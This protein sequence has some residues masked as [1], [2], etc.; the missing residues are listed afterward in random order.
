[1]DIL[2]QKKSMEQI[3]D[4]ARVFLSVTIAA[5]IQVLVPVQTFIITT[6]VCVVAD[7]ITGVAAASK[8]GERITSYGFRR[9]ILKFLMYSVAIILAQQMQQVYLTGLPVAY[10]I[11]LYIGLTEFWSVLENVGKYTGTDVLNAV[12]HWLVMK[13]P[14]KAK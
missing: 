4:L 8:A 2:I 5:C 10:T 7:F 6:L 9:T 11:A 3:F 13:L 12:R 14:S 1:M